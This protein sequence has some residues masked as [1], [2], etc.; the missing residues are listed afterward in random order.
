MNHDLFT[1]T[2]PTET[3]I[4]ELPFNVVKNYFD[5]QTAK[6][7][8]LAPGLRSQH[9]SLIPLHGFGDSLGPLAAFSIP[10]ILPTFPPLPQQPLVNLPLLVTLPPLNI[11][12]ELARQQR[13][14]TQS[15]ARTTTVETRT[16]RVN[17]PRFV[18][19][20]SIA[21]EQVQL[22]R[23]R[24]Y[25]VFKE[26]KNQYKKTLDSA[27]EDHLEQQFKNHLRKAVEEDAL[28]TARPAKINGQ[29]SGGVEEHG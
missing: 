1:T 18:N 12:E 28:S 20:S 14:S 3:S 4:D 22:W 24:F 7:H 25:N 29:N 9:P 15:P 19:Q 10:P 6:P 16:Q 11:V 26:I 17:G 2:V 23:K 5:E 8:A 21:P 27:D 13:E